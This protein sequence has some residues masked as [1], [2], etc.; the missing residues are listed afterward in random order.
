MYLGR[1]KIL[2][3]HPRSAPLLLLLPIIPL[4]TACAPVTNL[5]L[6]SYRDEPLVKEYHYTLGEKYAEVDGIRLCYQDMGHGPVVVIVPG[7]STLADYWYLTIPELAKHFRVI[8]IDLPGFGKSDKPDASYELAW[9]NERVLAFLDQ[10]NVQRFSVVGGSMGGHLALMLALDHPDRVERVIMMGSTGA[11]PQPGP[12]MSGAIKLV[13][14][15]AIIMNHLRA[16][17]PAI[18]E[19]IIR[20]PTPTTD[21]I[22]RYQ[23][24]IRADLDKYR[25]EGVASSRALCSIF[26]TSCR[27]RLS[28]VKVPILLVWGEYDEIHPL[29]DAEYM[30]DHIPGARLEV[31]PDAAH[32]AMIDQPAR[33]IAVVVPFLRGEHEADN[34]LSASLSTAGRTVTAEPAITDRP[35]PN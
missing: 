24:A 5:Q 4:L 15:D 1:T 31:I 18:Y 20:H 28:E 25:P 7:L 29:H 9:I 10:M 35:A 3:A 2:L 8:A 21:R 11:W 34:V 6:A 12:I 27:S 32:E 22:F 30:R 23:M 19:K 14:S 17:W 26:R 16:N 13:W 33:F